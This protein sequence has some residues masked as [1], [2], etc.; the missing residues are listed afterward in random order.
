MN[1]E[2]IIVGAGSMGMAAGY[3]L[4]SQGKKVL[5][6]DAFDPPHTEGSH[7]GETRIIRHAY[8]EG[9]NYVPMALRAQELWLA[10]EEKSNKKLFLKTGVLNAGDP[11]SQFIKNVKKSAQNYSLPVEVMTAAEMNEKWPGFRFPN[12]Y[13]GC[14]EKNSGVLMVEECVRAYREL[15]EKA[16]AVLRTNTIVKSIEAAGSSV[17]VKTDSETFTGEKMIVTAG[18][19]T[20][21]ILSTLGLELPLQPLRKTFSWFDSDENIYREGKFPAF[22]VNYPDSDE[23]YYGFP[24]IDEAGVKIGRHDEGQP[25]QPW[26]K[27]AGYGAFPED[28]GDVTGFA[29]QFMSQKLPVKYGKTCVYTNT[30]DS[31]F[32]I[33]KHPEF[34]NIFFACGFSGHGFKFASAVGEI[35]SQLAVD[36]KSKLDI[37]DFSMERFK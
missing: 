37:S 1:F 15:A 24:S 23:L 4:A 36:G 22:A 6:I 5:L 32:I 28:E 34:K 31:D 13:V 3:F 33:D 18:K 21:P 10:L 7:H 17:T 2:T 27:L 29:D 30:P 12:D 19:G 26:A 20:G 14:F 11:D 8:G 25:V 9:E 35:L 16:G